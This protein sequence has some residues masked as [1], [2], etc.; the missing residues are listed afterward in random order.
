MTVRL[1]TDKTRYSHG[2]PVEA[3]VRLAN[4]AG[5]AVSGAPCRV[6][7]MQEGRIIATERLAEDAEIPGTYG[8][9]LKEL[10]QGSMTIRVTGPEV[11]ELLRSE[12]YTDPVETVVVV[13]PED[14]VEM[15]NTRC[16]LPL[17]KRIAQSTGGMVVPPTALATAVEQLNLAPEVSEEVSQVPLWSRWGCLWLFLGCLTAE[18]VVRKLKGLA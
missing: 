13:D 8:A 16:N 3:T 15:R 14:S 7:A 2:E 18:W 4:L 6:T 11:Q 9:F 10:P 1:V 17:L 12:E 5:E